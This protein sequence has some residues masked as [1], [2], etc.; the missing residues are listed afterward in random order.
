MYII[1]AVQ[2]QFPGQPEQLPQPAANP[3]EGG[4]REC[5]SSARGT[6]AQTG[7]GSE[8]ATGEGQGVGGSPWPVGDCPGEN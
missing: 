7:R 2:T 1:A 6:A 3:G 4:G 8:G 5:E